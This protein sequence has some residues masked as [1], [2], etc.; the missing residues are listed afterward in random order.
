MKTPQGGGWVILRMTRWFFSSFRTRPPPKKRAKPP[1]AAKPKMLPTCKA[2]YDYD[3][4]DTD[5][6]TF[7][8]GT[9]IE[10]IKKGQP[11]IETLIYSII[12]GYNFIS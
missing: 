8:E 3:A 6:L 12:F 2:I 7:Q 1:I 10:I 11:L 9:V 4:G 5:E